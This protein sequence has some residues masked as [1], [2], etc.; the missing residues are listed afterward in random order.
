MI[1]YHFTSYSRIESIKKYGIVK[2]DVPITIMG[3]YNA[4]WFTSDRNPSSQGWTAGGDKDEIRITVEIPDG[5][6]KL[7]KWT[8][9]IK[10]ELSKIENKSDL[11]SRESWYN[12]LNEIGGGGQD[13]W[14]IYLGVVTTS[15]IKKN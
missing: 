3:G 6:P 4:P 12:I 7:K 9:V 5:D 11:K 10:E 14:Y 8:D 13:N 2:G 15:W 1:L